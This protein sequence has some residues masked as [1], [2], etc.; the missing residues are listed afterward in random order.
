MKIARYFDAAILKPD[1]TPEQVA[2]AI[3]EAIS[4]DSYTVCVRGCDIDLAVKM[5]EGTNTKVSCVLDFPYGYGGLEAKRADARAYA[6]KGVVDIDMV[7]NYGAARGGAWDVVEAEIKA[8]VEEAHAKGVNVKVIFETS[9]L[10]VEQIQKGDGGFH[11]GGCRFRKDLH[12]LQWLRRVGRSCSG[13][14]RNGEGPLQG[15]A[16]RRYPQLR[17]RQD[18][19]R[20]G[21]GSPRHWLQLL[22]GHLRWRTQIRSE[23]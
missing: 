2:D 7:M 3:K 15:E 20:Y 17:D 13:D 19:C 16:L 10:T 21:R 12:R 18:V 5:T 6:A 22:Q 23:S 1:M 8:V 11:R 14:A 9:Q 4:F